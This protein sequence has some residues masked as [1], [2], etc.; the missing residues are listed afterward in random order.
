M[1]PAVIAAFFSG[2][3]AVLTSFIALWLTRR[4]AE[5]ECQKRMDALREGVKLG[6]GR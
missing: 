4:H 1:D 6:E 3:T 2:V 5:Q